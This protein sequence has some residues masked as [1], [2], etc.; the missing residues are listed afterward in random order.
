MASRGGTPEGHLSK[1]VGRGG[2]REG[3]ERGKIFLYRC[4]ANSGNNVRRRGKTNKRNP[5]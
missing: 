2:A 4:P 3:E 5:Q 1:R